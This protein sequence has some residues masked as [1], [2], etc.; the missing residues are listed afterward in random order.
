MIYQNDQYYLQ[1]N[2]KQNGNA[3]KD[4]DCNEMVIKVGNVTKRKSTEELLFSKLNQ[5]WLFPLE[6]K[7][8]S[9]GYK[10][11]N[12]IKVQAWFDTEEGNYYSSNVASLK[13][14]TSI[15]N[16]NDLGDI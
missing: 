1:I 11:T 7:Q 4:T 8:T 3:V 13:I 6:Y 15:I 5:C 12:N 2:I 9:S 16:K 10:F 14:N